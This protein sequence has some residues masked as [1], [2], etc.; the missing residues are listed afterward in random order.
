MRGNKWEGGT[1]EVAWDDQ[2]I[3][4]WGR[5]CLGFWDDRKYQNIKN[6]FL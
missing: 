4:G 1:P 2:V 3:R 6:V 5:G